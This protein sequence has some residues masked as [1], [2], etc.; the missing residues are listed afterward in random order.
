MQMSEIKCSYKILNKKKE[1]I[2]FIHFYDGSIVT[3]GKKNWTFWSYIANK[4]NHNTFHLWDSV[5]FVNFVGLFYP[6]R[7]F[8]YLLREVD[9]VHSPTLEYVYVLAHLCD[10]EK[11]TI[12]SINFTFFSW[13]HAKF[14]TVSS[15]CSLLRWLFSWKISDSFD[16][17]VKTVELC[18]HL[19]TKSKCLDFTDFCAKFPHCA[20]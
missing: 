7:D 5:F 12:V 9:S 11:I 13:N 3:K 20:F 17:F 6:L 2:M 4:Y 8:F 15:N 14:L 1:I 16:N 19:V 10:A 18:I